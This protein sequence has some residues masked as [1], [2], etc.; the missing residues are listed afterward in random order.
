VIHIASQPFDR[1]T[2]SRDQR[3]V[4]RHHSALE[5]SVGATAAALERVQVG[6][7]VSL[8]EAGDPVDV[9][10]VRIGCRRRLGGHDPESARRPFVLGCREA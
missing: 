6:G 1:S 5:P 8:I 7:S 2:I 9:R 4:E 10:V 3:T